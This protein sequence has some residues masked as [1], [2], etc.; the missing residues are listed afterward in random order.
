MRR[1]RSSSIKSRGVAFLALLVCLFGLPAF[2]QPWDGNG[3]EGDP[4]LI[5]DAGDMENWYPVPSQANF[6]DP[7]AVGQRSVNF[8]DYVLLANDWL[9]EKPWPP[10]P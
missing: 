8:R 3:V 1:L 2:G 9:K 6:V 4:Y 10:R 7:E 5:Y